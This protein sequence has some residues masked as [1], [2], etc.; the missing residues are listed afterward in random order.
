MKGEGKRPATKPTG[1]CNETHVVGMALGDC[2]EPIDLQQSWLWFEGSQ[3]IEPQH[4]MLPWSRVA[5]KTQ[6]AKGTIRTP[7][8]A[9]KA[10]VAFRYID[11]L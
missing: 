4:C 2:E 7:N 10:N 1:A 8:S 9:T 3:G 6:S 5:A 11:L